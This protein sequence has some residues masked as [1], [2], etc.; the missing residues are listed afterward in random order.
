[1]QMRLK[2]LFTGAYMHSFKMIA[3][4]FKSYLL[5][6]KCF[7]GYL[8][9]HVGFLAPDKAERHCTL[10]TFRVEEI[11]AVKRK[12]IVFKSRLQQFLHFERMIHSNE[13]SFNQLKIIEVDDIHRLT[14]HITHILL[15]MSD[16]VYHGHW[17]ELIYSDLFYIC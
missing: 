15:Q 17:Y 7:G 4:I 2:A 10:L 1:M 8:A 6:C 5:L 16:S 13:K 12:F 14:N 9:T 3:M 11:K